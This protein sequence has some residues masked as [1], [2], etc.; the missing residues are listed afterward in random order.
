MPERLRSIVTRL[1]AY[2][3]DR[4]RSPRFRVRLTCTVSL[5]E[6]DDARRATTQTAQ[7]VT[8][9]T[10][11]LSAS[12]LALVLPAVRVGERYLTA[13]GTTLRIQLAHPTGALELLATPVHYDQLEG[14]AED[15]GFLVGVRIVEMSEQ[16]RAR[17]EAHLK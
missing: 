1:R 6:P 2:V 9:Y 13:A 15:K 4:R 10:R 17:Y 3:A 12:G 5:H 8:G 11:D 16:N 7:T 14:E